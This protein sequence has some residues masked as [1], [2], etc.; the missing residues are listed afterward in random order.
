M[1]SGFICGVMATIFY[2]VIS[3]CVHLWSYFDSKHRICDRCH[4]EQKWLDDEGRQG[5]FE[6]HAGGWVDIK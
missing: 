3:D 1:F 2:F 5:G 4:K 6:G